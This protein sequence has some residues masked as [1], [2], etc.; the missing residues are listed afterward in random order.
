VLWLRALS[1]LLIVKTRLGSPAASMRAA[2]APGSCLRAK[3]V[4]L[5]PVCRR[6]VE[7]SAKRPGWAHSNGV[8]GSP[9]SVRTRMNAS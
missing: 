7:Q 5:R 2:N 8:P 4:S 9:P 1:W 3:G 6:S